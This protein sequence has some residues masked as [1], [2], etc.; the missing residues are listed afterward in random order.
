M[1]PRPLLVGLALVVAGLGF[2]TAALARGDESGRRVQPVFFDER[3]HAYKP[4][5]P[6]KQTA[7]LRAQTPLYQVSYPRDW[8]ARE[9]RRPQC[10]PC[11]HAHDGITWEDFHDHV[12]GDGPRQVGKRP[13][14]HVFGV[15]PAYTGDAR[16]DAA[17]GDAYA[18]LLPARSEIEV[19]RL[20]SSA[21][22]DGT[23][24]ARLV[25]F[26]FYFEA[27]FVPSRLA[28]RTR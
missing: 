21:L 11:D 10:A 1:S 25:D 22:P 9:V 16:N 18:G 12:A 5:P 27:P 17:V 15:L 28:P 4:A 14:W 23:P 24:V 20:L 6:V 7:P 3:V 26:R 13:R 8:P 19:Q 2:A